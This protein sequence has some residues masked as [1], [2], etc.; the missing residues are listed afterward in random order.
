MITSRH[1]AQVVRTA[2]LLA[3][4]KQRRESG[5]FA[6]EGHKLLYDAVAAGVLSVVLDVLAVVLAGFVEC[7]SSFVEAVVFVT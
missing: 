1:N 6:A 3:N 4:A 7:V 5:E 2:G